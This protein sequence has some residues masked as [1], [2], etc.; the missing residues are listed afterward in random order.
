MIKHC[1]GSL[2]C[3]NPG[4]S[5]LFVEFLS[6]MPLKLCN[7][8]TNNQYCVIRSPF[9]PPKVLD[10]LWTQDESSA[11]VM[12]GNGGHVI[13]IASKTVNATCLM[14]NSGA[15]SVQFLSMGG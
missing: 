12:L 13:E 9:L 6:G 10:T 2:S 3:D 8:Q 1:C 15:K 5:Q 7:I 11:R 14:T 4:V